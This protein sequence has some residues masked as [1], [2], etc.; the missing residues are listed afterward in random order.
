MDQLNPSAGASVAPDPA[1]GRAG[2][3]HALK[4]WL[5]GDGYGSIVVLALLILVVFPLALDV[6][7]RKSVV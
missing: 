4:R 7:D 6:L 3:R 5:T 2:L 1:A